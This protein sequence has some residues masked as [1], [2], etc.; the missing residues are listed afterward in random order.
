MQANWDS[1]GAA[2]VHPSAINWAKAVITELAGFGIDRPVLSAGPGGEVG[3][4]WDG[5]SWSLDVAIDADG[6]MSYVYL[7][8]ASQESE[9]EG[10]TRDPR[11][12]LRFL[13]NRPALAPNPAVSKIPEN[14]RRNE[15]VLKPR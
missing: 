1:Y 7:D 12:L 6:N 5:G 9:R 10:V 11:D 8:G 13:T 2:P 15:K 3:F 14:A 4:S